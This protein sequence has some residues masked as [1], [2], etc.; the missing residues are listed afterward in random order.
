M[1]SAEFGKGGDRKNN[2][3]VHKSSQTHPNKQGGKTRLKMNCRFSLYIALCL[4]IMISSFALAGCGGEKKPAAPAAPQTIKL[5]FVGPLTGASAQDGESMRRGTELAIEIA[6]AAGGVGGKKIELAAA[7]DKSDPKEAAA[8]ANKFIADASILAVV[9]NYNSSC[10]LAGAP[11]YNK[12][13]LIQVS[14]GSSSPAV[15]NAGPFTF[16]TITTDAFQGKYL[17]NWA[18]K[19]EKF[20]NIAVVYENTDY[21]QGLLKVIEAEAPVLGAKIVAKEAYLLGETKDFSAVVSKVKAAKP[22]VIIVGGLY[23]ETALFAK[24]A[25]KNELK[26]PM[27]GVDGLYSDALIK[28]GGEAVEG[29][30]LTAFFHVS[31]PS[32]ETQNFIAA[33]KKKYNEEPG[34][35]A[36]YAF[37]AASIVIEAMSKGKAERKAIMEY[38]TPLKGFKGATGVIDFDANGDRIGTAL[39]LIVKGGKFQVL[40]K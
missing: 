2:G 37:D 7:D 25:I 11:I 39:K 35:Y 8:I 16:R 20:K 15:S 5:G 36:A 29:L 26:V 27:M 40:D 9:G 6:N 22:D 18:V 12:A 3:P 24:Q 17:I 38:V 21:G 1:L 34:T 4:I 14:P 10:T 23:N 33:Y 32:K 19:D 28:L 13:G 30:K 31:S